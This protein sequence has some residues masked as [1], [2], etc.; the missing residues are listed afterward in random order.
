V[1]H[2][3]SPELLVLHGVRVKGMA[4]GAAVASRFGLDRHVVEELLLDYEAQGWVTRV[5]F[6]GTGGWALT[7]AGR[8]E[9][10]RRL[11]AELEETTARPEV[12]AVHGEFLTLNSRFLTAV[13]NWQIRPERADP[14]AANDHTDW[15]WDERVLDDL[16]RLERQLRPVGQQLAAALDRFSGYPERYSAALDKVDRGQRAWVDQPRIDSCHTVWMELHEDLLA[17]LG[18]ERG[19]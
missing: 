17:T 18:L 9:N 15:R 6:A 11:A 10:E 2:A 4:D 16:R 1:A 19:A 7:A 8:A 13:T 12:E 3:S 5:R 14:L